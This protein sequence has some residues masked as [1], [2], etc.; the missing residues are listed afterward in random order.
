MQSAGSASQSSIWPGRPPFARK[1]THSSLAD[2][3]SAASLG[4]TAGQPRAAA[5]GTL[6]SDPT[7]S[8][9]GRRAAEQPKR[10]PGY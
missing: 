4:R 2:A 7:Q 10:W 1:R 6:P 3:L 9:P 5:A 8:D